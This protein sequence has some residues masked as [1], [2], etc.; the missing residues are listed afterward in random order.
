MNALAQSDGGLLCESGDADRLA[1]ADSARLLVLSDT[2]GHY[3]VLESIVREYGPLCDALLFAGDGMW[4]IVQYLENAQDSD[5]LKAALP[6][7]VA[8]VA[9]NGDGEQ[10]R[11]SLGSSSAGGALAPEDAPGYSL[12]VPARQIVRACGYSILIAH[13]NRHSVD[14][15]LDLLVDSARAMDCDIAVFGHT[16]MP[17]AETY[18]G[19]LALNPGSPARPRGRHG[20][21]FALVDLES[22]STEPKVTFVSVYPGARGS[23]RFSE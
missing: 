16:H 19:I 12:I 15:S 21:S 10:Y 3:E 11:V 4:D 20:P 6:P 1:R 8:F 23:F 5:R 7:V 2:H 9:G 13:G 22:T 14:V 18:S 17:C